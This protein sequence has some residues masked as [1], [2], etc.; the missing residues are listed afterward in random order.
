[1]NLVSGS[2]YVE[3]VGN[4]EENPY[5]FRATERFLFKYGLKP[6]SPIKDMIG[7]QSTKG[8]HV[9]SKFVRIRRQCGV[10]IDDDGILTAIEGYPS[11]CKGSKMIEELSD[12]YH[13]ADHEDK[14]DAVICALLVYLF[15][16]KRAMLVSPGDSVPISEGWIWV[17]KDKLDKQINR[18]I[19]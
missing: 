5:L 11:A 14:N 18:S 13:E 1:M 15:V 10:W 7:S 6:L 9:L 3:A 19:L 2:S 12:H 8:I 4:S 16:E 17:P